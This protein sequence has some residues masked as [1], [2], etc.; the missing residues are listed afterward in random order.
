MPAG[1]PK[2]KFTKEQVAEVAT[3]AA[4]LTIEQMADYFGIG[5][6]SFTNIMQRQPEV[7]E[8]YKRGKAKAIGAVAKGLLQ[9]ALAGD[10]AA[11]M[12]YLKTQAGW[13]ETNIQEITGANGTTL[14]APV[15][16]IVGVAPKDES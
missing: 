9:Q 14:Q 11:A 4:V 12:F 13:R 3:L 15:F 7:E 8:A 2:L 1:R 16:N 5:R 10:K 6:N